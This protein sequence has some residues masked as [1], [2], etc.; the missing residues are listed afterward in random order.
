MTE[1]SKGEPPSRERTAGESAQGRCFEVAPEGRE[2]ARA[3]NPTGPPVTE[4]NAVFRAFV[5][6]LNAPKIGGTACQRPIMGRH[7][8]LFVSN[9]FT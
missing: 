4:Q 6:A 9:I 3:K 5:R 8:F 7:V 2:K 1:S